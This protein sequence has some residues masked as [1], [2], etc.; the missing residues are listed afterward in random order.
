MSSNTPNLDLLKKNPS[1]DGNDTF[2]IKTMLNDNWDK[3]DE[4][5]SAIDEEVADHS[6]RLNTASYADVVL[7][8]GLQIMNSAKTS[9]FSLRSIKGRTLVNWLGRDGAFNDFKDWIYWSSSVPVVSNNTVTVTGN[10]AAINPQITHNYIGPV[11]KVGDKLF[12]RAKAKSNN[13]C[14]ALRVY[15]YSSGITYIFYA[16]STATRY[17][18]VIGTTYDLFG[19]IT[20]TQ[21]LVDNWSTTGFVLVNEY[22]DA[23]SSNNAS[24]VYSEAALYKVSEPDKG[25]TDAELYGKYPYVDSVKPVRNPYALLHGENLADSF[26][27]WNVNFPRQDASKGIIKGPFEYELTANEIDAWSG[28]NSIPVVPGVQYTFSMDHNGEI[29][30]KYYDVSGNSLTP[31]ANYTSSRSYTSI[32]PAG[33]S[34]VVLYVRNSEKTGVF[35]FKNPMLNIGS[36]VKSFKPREYS[37]LALQ[38][39]LYAHPVSYSDADE[40]FVSDGQYFKLTKWKNIALDGTLEYKTD[41]VRTG[42]KT[43]TLA[44]ATLVAAASVFPYA[45]KFDGSILKQWQETID[46]GDYFWFQSNNQN[47]YLTVSN[48]DTGW[49]DTYTPTVD[50]VKAYFM[51]WRMYDGGAAGNPYNGSGTKTWNSIPGW[52]TPTYYTTMLPTKP[53]I[54]YT[55]YQLVYQLETPTVE[56]IMSEGALTL[57]EGDNQVEVGTGVVLRESVQP[58]QSEYAHVINDINIP[59]SILKYKVARFIDVYQNGARD[60]WEYR[61]NLA[62]GNERRVKYGGYDPSANYSVTYLMLEKYPNTLFSGSAATNEKAILQD[63]VN[64]NKRLSNVDA[65]TQ[66][67]SS[68]ELGIKSYIDNNY[69]NKYTLDTAN[70]I[71]NSTGRLDLQNWTVISGSWS[72]SSTHTQ[73]KFFN[74]SGTVASGTAVGMDSAQIAVVGGK[75]YLIGADFYTYTLSSPAAAYVFILNAADD[76]S[77]YALAGDLGKDWHRKSAKF[78]IPS[79]VNAVKLR[80]HIAGPAS[81]TRAFARIKFSKAADPYGNPALDHYSNDGDI[82]SLFQSA[83]SGKTAIASAIT[84]KGVA[85][86]GSDTFSTLASKI[87]QIS[88]GKKFAMGTVT[89]NGNSTVSIFGLS[90]TPSYA[91]LVSPSSYAYYSCAIRGSSISMYYSNGSYSYVNGTSFSSNGVSGIA[92]PLNGVVTWNWLVIE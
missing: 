66:K 21:Q 61:G 58:Q 44:N 89:G 2:N 4:A 19:S 15:L 34:Y 76:S 27:S 22:N 9:R 78:T 36:T 25:L 53:A 38:T 17:N 37:M 55:P 35:S 87:T 67:I 85:A 90:F 57:M 81:S 75:E 49:G 8:P 86:S 73:P 43:I 83:S 74:N 48:T 26:L 65:I 77:I 13:V 10:G 30:T 20:V 39:D 24:S 62:F 11:P 28:S 1:T 12:I 63:V 16:G 45:I 71:Q 40:V 52:G 88:T 91:F 47:F 79:G 31:T 68:G 29:T 64:V 60:Q 50:E 46:S 33:A 3:I 5:V 51:G 18:P 56:P 23:A 14:S 7:N 54:G 42:Y 72:T 84:G 59:G 32:A 82:E 41:L 70:L 80:L 69:Y 6:A 92:V